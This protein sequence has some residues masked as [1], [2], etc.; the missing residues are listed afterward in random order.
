MLDCDIVVSEFELQSDCYIH[1]QTIIPLGK[2]WTLYFPSYG[3][4][5]TIDVLYKDYFGIR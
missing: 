2:V 5:R 3:L 1:F 4:N